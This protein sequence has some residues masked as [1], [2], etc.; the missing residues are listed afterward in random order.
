MALPGGPMLW[1]CPFFSCW[2]HSITKVCKSIDVL[3]YVSGYQMRAIDC[4]DCCP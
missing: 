4:L 2:W 3:C 1:S